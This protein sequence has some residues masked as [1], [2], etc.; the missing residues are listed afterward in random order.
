MDDFLFDDLSKFQ[1]QFRSYGALSWRTCLGL[2]ALLDFLAT[3]LPRKLRVVNPDF[4]TVDQFLPD[5]ILMQEEYQ[6]F[7]QSISEVPFGVI[8]RFLQHNCGYIGFIFSILCFV[9]A[10]MDASRNRD[11]ALM[12]RD[13]QRLLR[14][15]KDADDEDSI[16]VIDD[17]G[18]L[19]DNIDSWVAFYFRLFVQLMCLPVGF[20]WLMSKGIFLEAKMDLE[21]H[22][23]RGERELNEILRDTYNVDELR[24]SSTLTRDKN[25]S[26]GFS[27]VRQ[28]VDVILTY[29]Y[30]KGLVA[31]KA[32]FK[33]LMHFIRKTIGRAVRNPLKFAAKVR[34]VLTVLRWVKYIQPIF[35]ATN[36]LKG[37]LADPTKKHRQRQKRIMM[38][39]IRRRLFHEMTEDDRREYA[40][41][42]IQ[43]IFRGHRIRKT[44]RALN[45]LRGNK[46][47][48]AAI[49]LQKVFRAKLKNARARIARKV[50]EFERLKLK[51]EL[52]LKEKKK[53]EQLTKMTPTER[54]RLYELEEE[55]QL[56]SARLLSQRMLIKPDTKFSVT[57]K[58][59]FC[60]CVIF[61]IAGLVWNPKLKKYKDDATG[62]ALSVHS[63]TKSYILPM[64]ISALPECSCEPEVAQNWKSKLMFAV[65]RKQPVLCGPSPWFCRPP[66]STA[67]TWYIQMMEFFIDEFLLF[68]GLVVF[69]D[70][71]ISFL[72][73][74]IDDDTG[75]LAPKPFFKRWILPGLALQLLVNPKMA[76]TGKALWG[77]LQQIFDIGP[78]RVWR[79]TSAV[80]YPLFVVLFDFLE[81]HI[82]APFVHDQNHQSIFSEVKSSVVG[83]HKDLEDSMRKLSAL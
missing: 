25:L 44:I 28:I 35:G 20:Y 17:L 22:D 55:L 72:T 33:E 6:I 46:E 58:I 45:L 32:I 39:K 80:F 59:L 19:D 63:V 51:S 74:E 18:Y 69:L 16:N 68:V 21:G 57:W 66:F 70:V 11:R 24:D 36:K 30:A 15:Q 47:A 76:S 65:Q 2:A 73:G 48:M 82:W 10:F 27:I 29:A 8:L 43:S 12:E 31:K 67:R 78:V 38:Q 40:A 56:E 41:R 54:R 26:L 62:D 77:F 50:L 53:N 1:E 42:K 79:W 52:A 49:K 37:N 75:V 60:V 14:I 61:E 7:G 34:K 83:K 64:P 3:V 23:D 5:G 13:R 4:E 81:R 9:E 71:P